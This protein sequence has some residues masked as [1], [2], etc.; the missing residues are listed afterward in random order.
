MRPYYTVGSVA[1]IMNVARTTVH[2]WIEHGQLKMH[3]LPG[4]ELRITHILCRRK[5]LLMKSHMVVLVSICGLGISCAS[6]NGKGIS[7]YEHLGKRLGDAVTIN[8]KLVNN[9]GDVIIDEKDAR[10]IAVE[11]KETYS[12]YWAYTNKNNIQKD[13]LVTL[14]VELWHE[15]L[16]LSIPEKDKL[17]NALFECISNVPEKEL[18]DYVKGGIGLPTTTIKI[19]ADRLSP[20]D[21]FLPETVVKYRA[22]NEVS[23]YGES[24]KGIAIILIL[25]MFREN[26]EETKELNLDKGISSEPTNQRQRITLFE[27]TINVPAISIQETKQR[28]VNS[29]KYMSDGNRIVSGS[30]DGKIKIW[31]LSTRAI[32]KEIIGHHGSVLVVRISNNGR[33]IASGGG[34]K[35]CTLWDIDSGK[36]VHE[37]QGFKYDVTNLYFTNDDKSIVVISDVATIYNVEDGKIIRTFN[38]GGG[39]SACCYDPSR[40]QLAYIA[41][42]DGSLHILDLQTNTNTKTII[43]KWGYM[44]PLEFSPD[45]NAIAGGTFEG[46]VFVWDIK[47]GREKQLEMHKGPV[48]SLC[49]NPCGG[50][51]ATGGSD[52][53]IIVWDINDFSLKGLYSKDPAKYKS[54][55]GPDLLAGSIQ[56]IAFSPNGEYFAEGN[57]QSVIRIWKL[58]E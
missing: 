37:F 36:M 7:L 41:R 58:V 38:L 5:W 12:D 46:T 34:D 1:R 29:V 3:S 54:S 13:Q 56:S 39:S 40:G 51:L 30:S 25:D 22:I 18:T 9:N 53:T 19:L 2:Y 50:L 31:D 4:K 43:E 48:T 52:N 49:F 45:G 28:W 20:N 26:Y 21:I 16:G 23:T 47:N 24:E 33:L 15:A 10:D 14:I 6:L 57:S 42:E 27:E 32:V 55:D 17:A 44:N 11:L 35:T 8:D